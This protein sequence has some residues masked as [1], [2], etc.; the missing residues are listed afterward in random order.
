M[1]TQSRCCSH[2][3]MRRIATVFRC[4]TIMLF[5]FAALAASPS[6]NAATLSVNTIDDV[7]ANDGLCSLRE[8]ITAVN[9]AAPSGNLNGECAAGDGNNDENRPACRHV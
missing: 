9:K 3:G 1:H 4:L 7:V 6:G 2:V 5:G 8:A